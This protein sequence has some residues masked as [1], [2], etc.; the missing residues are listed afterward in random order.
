MVVQRFTLHM[1]IWNARAGAMNAL[2]LAKMGAQ[3]QLQL[4]WPHLRSPINFYI[5]WT[6]CHRCEDMSQNQFLT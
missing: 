2:G 3:L 4:G 6:L 5:V 1:Q